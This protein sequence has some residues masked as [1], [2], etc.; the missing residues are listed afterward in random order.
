VS[1]SSDGNCGAIGTYTDASHKT[2]AFVESETKGSWGSALEVPGYSSLNIGG[3]AGN[4]M[5][6]SCPSTGN[7]SAG[8]SYTD[9]S[10]DEQAFYVGE[11]NGTWGNAI[12]VPGFSTLNTSNTA[13]LLGSLSCSSP[14]NC[15][16]GGSYTNTAGQ[17]QAFVDNEVNGTWAGAIEAPATNE[18]NVGGGAAITSIDCPSNGNCTATGFYLDGSGNVQAFVLSEVSGTWQSAIEIA[19]L[20][21]LNV[22]GQAL[23][24]EIGCNTAGNCSIAGEYTDVAND[25]QAFAVSSTNGTWGSAIEVPGTATLNAGGNAGLEAI[26][27]NGPGD[28]SATGSYLDASSFSQAFVVNEVGGTWGSAVEAPGTAALNAGGGADLGAIS[29]ISVGNCT[30]S[31]A[32]TDSSSKLQS[33]VID[34]KGGTWASAIELPGTDSLNVGSS[35]YA[36]SVSCND[37]GS[38]SVGGYYTDTTGNA[39][40]YVDSSAADIFVPGRPAFHA[41]S[42]TTGEVSVTVVGKP[43]SGGSPVLG[44]QYSVNGGK[45]SKATGGD[46]GRFHINHLGAKGYR[47]EVRAVN[48]IGDG[49]ASRPVTVKVR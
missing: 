15:S 4:A 47:I 38:C 2:Q 25:Y 49:V 28:C 42:I 17:A 30:A 43:A 39:Q 16:A 44:Y 34:E 26:Q 24:F 37:D 22:G 23:P 1:C 7:C 19:G 18:L 20:A 27:C 8:G 3:V 12:E 9:G 6:I 35:S 14:G 11:T 40:A 21:A 13:G 29:C 36:E 48:L 31:G 10:N 32:F 45:W 5:Y 33:M 46:S 41:T